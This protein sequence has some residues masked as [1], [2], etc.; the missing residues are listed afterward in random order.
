MAAPRRYFV[1]TPGGEIGPHSHLELRELLH[2]RKISRSDRLR[3]ALGVNVGTVNDILTASEEITAFLDPVLPPDSPRLR[4][5]TNSGARSSRRTPVAGRRQPVEEPQPFPL[6]SVL[7]VIA[8]VVVGSAWWWSAPTYSAPVRTPH[9][10]ETVVPETVVPEL[11]VPKTTTP[12]TLVPTATLT[13]SMASWALGIEGAITV[14]L[15]RPA[16][17]DLEIPLAMGGTASPGREMQALP[18]SMLIPRG[19]TSATVAVRPLAPSA[20][21]MQPPH[22]TV[23]IGAGNGWRLGPTSEITVP[24]GSGNGRRPGDPLLTWLSDLPIA[25]AVCALHEP[26]INRSFDDKEMMI[27]GVT[28]GSGIGVHAAPD[29]DPPTSLIFNL[30]GAYDEFL[31]DFGIDDEASSQ[32]SVVC[33]V[34]VDGRLAFDSGMITYKD[35]AR[36]L[37]IPVSGAR[38]LKLMVLNGDRDYNWDHTDWAGARL[39][40]RPP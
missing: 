4:R 31:S 21:R 22:V 17:V 11:V 23:V 5:T 6:L 3:T 26:R 32:G 24:L 9:V 13:G 19:A 25:S 7:I 16:P 35:P 37:R 10:P 18:Q 2:A 34:W 14:Q 8:A 40:A 38:E 36:S 33:Q 15:D 30:S 20:G 29:A 12:E 39:L 1:L 27:E 28:Y